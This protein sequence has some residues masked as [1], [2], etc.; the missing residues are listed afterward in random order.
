MQ[1]R[2]DSRG[3]RRGVLAILVLGAIAAA[4]AG[5]DRLT[6]RRAI[7]AES[8]RL[9]AIA[10]LAASGYRRQVDKF[11]LVATTLSA[12][13]DVAALLDSRTGAAATRLN[14][15]LAGLSTALD[16]SVIY[17]IDDGGTTI[18]A[19]NWRQ[20]DS[21]VGENYGFRP[22]FKQAMARGQYE[23]YALGTRSRIA[24]LFVARRV[25]TVG[26]KLGVIVV[27]IRFDRLERE[28]AST[29]GTPSSRASRA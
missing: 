29:I 16:A 3:L 1:P 22:Y 26:G 21:F 7:A 24:G 2:L 9:G 14:T 18:A 11:Q 15:R 28:W 23:Q 4:V 25:K 17:L 27:K 6:E 13:P 8:E 5:A 20:A 10:K 19:S 12:D